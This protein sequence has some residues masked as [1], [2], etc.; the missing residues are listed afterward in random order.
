M[1]Y[2]ST[3]RRTLVF[4]SAF[5]LLL[6]SFSTRSNAQDI[7]IVERRLGEIVAKGELT[8][9]QAQVM[10]GALHEHAGMRHVSMQL[11]EEFERLG[12]PNEPVE[13][14]RHE[15]AERGIEGHR[16]FGV[17]EVILRINHMMKY[18]KEEVDLTQELERHLFEHLDIP[19]PQIELVMD[20]ARNL[21]EHTRPKNQRGE[22]EIDR[23]AAVLMLQV[24]TLAH[25]LESKV[26]AESIETEMIL[27]HWNGLIEQKISGKVE[28]SVEAG[29]L[30][31]E[32]A[33]RIRIAVE[34]RGDELSRLS[35]QNR[36]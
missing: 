20:L 17:M 5:L 4:A 1:N 34:R 28:E 26:R 12:I 31:E 23:R 2:D 35:E 36:D 30:S 8:L 10:L 32:Q 29:L 9:E 16:N 25:N 24:E 22:F 19:E 14:V 33:E 3:F 27:D 18:S 13:R 21:R 7:E 15:L 6:V 11:L